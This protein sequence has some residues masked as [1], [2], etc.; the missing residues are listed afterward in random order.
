MG[1]QWSR[2]KCATIICNK[3]AEMGEHFC[4]EC[5]LG[6]EEGIEPRQRDIPD[7]DVPYSVSCMSCG[8]GYDIKMTEKKGKLCQTIGFKRCQFCNG[9]VVMERSDLGRI[10]SALGSRMKLGY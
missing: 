4:I 5:Q 8:R 2:R 6:D 9:T 1:N 10:G 3:Y 7:V